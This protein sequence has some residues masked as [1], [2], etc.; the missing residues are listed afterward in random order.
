MLSGRQNGFALGS[1]Q[2]GK[3]V[4]AGTGSP[5]PEKDEVDEGSSVPEVAEASLL[6]VGWERSTSIVVVLPSLRVVAC[7]AED[8][9]SLVDEEV[10]LVV[11]DELVDVIELPSSSKAD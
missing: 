7:R 4:L 11:E 3:P 9:S 5:V 6:S 1:S 10:L 2:V 8:G